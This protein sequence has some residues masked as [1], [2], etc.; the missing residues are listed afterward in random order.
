MD[1]GARWTPERVAE[2]QPQLR[3]LLNEWDPIGVY[4]PKADYP[5]DEYDCLMGPLLSRLARGETAVRLAEFLRFEL[6][7]HFGLDPDAHDVELFSEKV[8]TWFQDQTGS[9]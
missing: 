2:L 5:A 4:D 6:E 3:F 1:L 7:D 9:R 8:S